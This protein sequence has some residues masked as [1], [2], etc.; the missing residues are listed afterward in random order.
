MYE[1]YFTRRL[2]E[3]L[4]LADESDDA[5]ERCVHLKASRYY[6][7]LL[8]FSEKRDSVRHPIRL[9][10]TVRHGSHFRRVT[11]S[12]LSSGG[13]RITLDEPLP[14]GAPLTLQ[15]DG[16]E[17]VDGFVVWQDGDQVG[18]RFAKPLHPALV[19]AAVALAGEA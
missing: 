4:T 7:E 16:F 17:P 5:G 12:D 3:A 9:R 18:C 14:S 8:Q 2:L 19:D 1:A 11:L 6:R 10:A 13:F 15:M